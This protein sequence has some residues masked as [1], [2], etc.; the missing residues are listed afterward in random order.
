MLHALLTGPGRAHGDGGRPC[1]HLVGTGVQCRR[2]LWRVHAHGRLSGIA[3]CRSEFLLD[4]LLGAI[5][6][7]QMWAGGGYRRG[8][9]QGEA[10]FC[11]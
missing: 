4:P 5:S 1:A 3:R 8:I 9:V 10:S 6:D 7:G 2:Q 11:V